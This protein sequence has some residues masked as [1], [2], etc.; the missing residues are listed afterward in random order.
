M[1]QL[2]KAVDPSKCKYKVRST[3][4]WHP[5]RQCNK[6]PKLDGYCLQ[7]HPDALAK[8]K[9]EADAR[10]KAKCDEMD[11]AAKRARDDRTRLSLV[12]EMAALLTRAS[13]GKVVTPELSQ[14]IDTLLAKLPM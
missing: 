3:D 1:N 9:R 10:W 5:R 7:H 6:A 4:V 14:Q 2:V 11:A 13:L 8:R 12:P